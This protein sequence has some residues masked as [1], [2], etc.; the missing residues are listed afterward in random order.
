MIRNTNYPTRF[1]LICRR[2]LLLAA[3]ILPVCSQAHNAAG[4]VLQGHFI[5]SLH[6]SFKS[7]PPPFTGEAIKLDAALVGRYQLSK[8]GGV[9]GDQVLT[10]SN[11]AL[12]MG[13]VSR[14]E[15]SGSYSQGSDGLLV[16][17]LEE[18]RI[19]PAGGADGAVDNTSVLECYI[20]Q[21]FRMARCV[22]HSLVT[23]QQG[24]EPR[25]L[26]VTMAGSLERQQ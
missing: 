2:A 7:P 8:N 15:I 21:R 24:E 25:P 10:F 6:G 9:V 12:P 3:L 16:M 19:D 20:V 22:L 17:Y 18:D 13:V 5:V 23:Y 11:A 4:G 1:L 14:A 26:P